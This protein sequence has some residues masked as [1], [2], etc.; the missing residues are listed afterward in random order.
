MDLVYGLELAMAS[1]STSESGGLLVSSTVQSTK[2]LRD[3]IQ[4]TEK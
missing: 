1:S 4:T 3:S 2:M